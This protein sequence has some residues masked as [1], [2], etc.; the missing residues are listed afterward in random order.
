M[1]GPVPKRWCSDCG[2]LFD[3]DSTNALRCP[4]CQSAAITLRNRRPP[5]QLRGY[6]AEHDKV[7]EE[8]LKQWTRG[9]ACALCGKP[10]WDKSKLDLAHNST[11]TGYRGLA[12]ASCNRGH[13]YD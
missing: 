11:R 2:E 13:K 9:Q 12:H 1:T 4:A 5:R 3:M 8:L 10:T 7:R 6:D